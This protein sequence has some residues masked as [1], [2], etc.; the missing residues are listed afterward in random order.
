MCLLPPPRKE[1]LQLFILDVGTLAVIAPDL[2]GFSGV[3]GRISLTVVHVIAKLL[4]VR[5]FFHP[6]R[7][8]V[9]KEVQGNLIPFPV[10]D[11][12]TGVRENPGPDHLLHACL[13]A[14]RTT[15][16]V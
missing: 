10:K 9:V 11:S 6:L 7:L 4:R 2:L 8:L 1:L 13:H 15:L 3:W 16:V 5:S 14:Q 12:V